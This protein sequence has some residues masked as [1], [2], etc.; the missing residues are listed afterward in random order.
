MAKKSLLDTIKPSQT[1]EEL[2]KIA[3]QIHSAGKKTKTPLP[4]PAD[5]N[6]QHRLTIDLPKWLVAAIKSEGKKNGLTVRGVILSILL[7]KFKQ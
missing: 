2:D 7:E 3:E 4:S 1:A 5:E 6:E